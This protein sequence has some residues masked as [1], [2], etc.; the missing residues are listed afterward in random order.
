M[1]SHNVYLVRSDELVLK[2]SSAPSLAV[3]RGSGKFRCCAYHNTV[4]HIF[5][6]LHDNKY[7]KRR[8]CNFVNYDAWHIGQ[9]TIK[10]SRGIH[11]SKIFTH[12]DHRRI[13]FAFLEQFE[14]AWIGI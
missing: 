13:L 1:L 11:Y 4:H 9:H 7:N 2:A 3:C 6:D 8:N 12:L 10:Y 14:A 5:H